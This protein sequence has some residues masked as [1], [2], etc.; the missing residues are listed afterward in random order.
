MVLHK[1]SAPLVKSR[2]KPKARRKQV[3]VYT[4]LA[5]PRSAESTSVRAVTSRCITLFGFAWVHSG[6]HKCPAF[7]QFRAVHSGASSG[8][9]FH[10]DSH[11]FTR[12]PIGV[13]G[14]IRVRL[15]SLSVPRDRPVHS[16]S[17][18]FIQLA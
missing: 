3:N 16:C 7:N 10:L 4:P 18:G 6:A 14:F 8:R 2:G 12:A 11:G 13:A 9:L 5:G 17:L 1:I 15:G